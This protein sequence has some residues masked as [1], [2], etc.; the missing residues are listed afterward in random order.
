MRAALRTQSSA[1]E[2]EIARGST[3]STSA[4]RSW[5]DRSRTGRSSRGRKVRPASL[6]GSRKT[7]STSVPWE[8]IACGA[9]AEVSTP[10]AVN[11]RPSGEARTRGLPLD[12]EHEVE[13]VVGM[14]RA[15]KAGAPR[16]EHGRPDGHVHPSGNGWQAHGTELRCGAAPRIHRPQPRKD[17]DALERAERITRAQRAPAAVIE[18]SIVRSNPVA[19]VTPTPLRRPLRLVLCRAGP[20]RQGAGAPPDKKGRDDTHGIQHV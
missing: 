16:G 14:Q 12:R 1:P 3:S 7:S 8:S 4:D 2:L 18:E 11:H 13:R 20:C 6:S 19:V 9:S 15:S 5:A 10:A 17:P